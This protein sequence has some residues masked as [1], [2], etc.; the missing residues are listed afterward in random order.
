[1]DFNPETPSLIRGLTKHL[2][3]ASDANELIIYYLVHEFSLAEKCVSF[4]SV[5]Q[6]TVRNSPALLLHFHAKLSS[7]RL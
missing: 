7:R 4:A 5:L 6:N 2:L 3:S 1:M